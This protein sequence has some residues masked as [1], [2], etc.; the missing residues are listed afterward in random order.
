MVTLR[1]F[2]AMLLLSPACASSIVATGADASAPDAAT[3]VDRPALEGPLPRLLRPMTG[4]YTTRGAPTLRWA[5][6]PGATSARVLVCLDRACARVVH[7]LTAAGDR[8]AVPTVLRPVAHFWRVEVGGRTSATWMLWPSPRGA[9]TD[10]SFGQVADFNGDGVHDLALV[11]DGA[12]AVYFGRVGGFGAAP[13]QTLRASADRYCGVAMAGDLDGDGYVDLLAHRCAP[14]GAA[15]RWERLSGS[16]TGTL[17]QAAL[18]LPGRSRVVGVGDIDGDGVGD[19]AAAD[20]TVSAPYLRLVLGSGRVV[21]IARPPGAAPLSTAL[22]AAVWDV[23]GDGL[24]DVGVGVYGTSDE[25]WALRLGASASPRWSRLGAVPEPAGRNVIVRAVTGGDVDGDGASDVLVSKTL[26]DNA[27]RRYEL[28][29]EVHRGAA[30]GGPAAAPTSVL[31]GPLAGDTPPRSVLV[32]DV[33]GNGLWDVFVGANDQ[34]AAGVRGRVLRFQGTSVGLSSMPSPLTAYGSSRSAPALFAL[35]I[36]DV[37][38]DGL[39][40]VAVLGPAAPGGEATVLRAY[41]G[42]VTDAPAL[43]EWA[44]VAASSSWF[45]A[46]AVGSN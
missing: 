20:P 28:S 26:Y 1:C 16:A 12:I 13:D 25:A 38:G 7:D 39:R 23:D 2:A 17:P 34:D 40:D 5:M 43:R 36:G 3:P 4:A 31:M 22:P 44:G 46:T 19:L 42:A 37:N 11:T 27:T 6:P 21:E 30:G 15:L 33:D 10:G 29:V 32:T 35:G 24:D 14:D 8:V 9:P 41:S 45:E 18:T